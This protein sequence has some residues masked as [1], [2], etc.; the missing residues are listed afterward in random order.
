MIQ[1]Y[2]DKG[3]SISEDDI[4]GIF[5]Q[6][7]L[8]LFECH[9][10]KDKKMM[11]LHRDLKPSNIFLDDKRNPKIGDFGFAKAINQNVS[12]TQKQQDNYAKT[13]LGTPTYMSPELLTT[14]NAEYNEKSDIWSLGCIIYEMAALRPPF[15]AEN[16]LTLALKIKEGQFD[17]MPSQYSEELM[18][19]VKW[20]LKVEPK[21]RPN[22]EDLLNL[23]FVSM[24]LRE[25]ALRKNM[26]HMKKKE[27]E[28]KR[29]EQELKD[30]EEEIAKREKE[31]EEKERQVEELERAV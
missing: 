5:M 24:R 30:R 29:K 4:W 15:Q 11:I 27:E 17:R 25:K 14:D 12:E 7:V 3:D 13:Y 31:I 26:Q 18:R 6:L 28:V 2:K 9:R 10:R 22:V 20:M 23:P 16:E 1:K 21:Q 19:T 8:A